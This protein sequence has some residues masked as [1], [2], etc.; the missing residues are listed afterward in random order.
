MN[1][2]ACLFFLHVVCEIQVVAI[3]LIGQLNK[4]ISLSWMKRY[5]TMLLCVTCADI[6]YNSMTASVVFILYNSSVNVFRNWQMSVKWTLTC[7]PTTF[8]FLPSNFGALLCHS[9]RYHCVPI[10]ITRLTKTWPKKI[11]SSFR[12]CISVTF[13]A[14]EFDKQCLQCL[15]HLTHSVSRVFL[16]AICHMMHCHFS[17]LWVTLTY[18]VPFTK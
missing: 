14:E 6:Q 8:V 1:S 18:Q 13:S 2:F 17:L 5:G 3:E 9:N 16:P 11:N 10:T 12:N 15:F 4:C 7:G